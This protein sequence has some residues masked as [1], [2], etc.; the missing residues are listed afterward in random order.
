MKA[1]FWKHQ[2]QVLRILK[3][4]MQY[5]WQPTWL[6]KLS[7]EIRITRA[8]LF[9]ALYCHI[10]FLEWILCSLCE[11]EMSFNVL[12]KYS[13]K[14]DWQETIP[15]DTQYCS[16]CEYGS[17]SYLADFFFGD[18]AFCYYLGKG[19]FSYITPT[20][21]LFD[22]CKCC[23]QFYFEEEKPVE[24]SVMLKCECG[25]IFKTI[26]YV[27]PSRKGLCC[28]DCSEYIPNGWDGEDYF[29]RKIQASV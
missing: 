3:L 4:E 6:D 26:A 27:P 15:K 18:G 29:G 25:F 12:K 17:W 21:L 7:R 5:C 1:F 22:G 10:P 24:E 20:D 2:K 28:P 23:G 9:Y 19:D 16:G 11:L 13:K 14:C 8:N